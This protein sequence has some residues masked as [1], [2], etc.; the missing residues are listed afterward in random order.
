VALQDVA[1]IE[2]LLDFMQEHG[3]ADDVNLLDKHGYSALHCATHEN[4]NEVVLML[5]LRC[6]KIDCTLQNISNNTPLHYFCNN[7]VDPNVDHILDI[8]RQKHAQI[9]AVNDAGETPLHR[10]VLNRKPL[11][12]VTGLIARQ[13]NVNAQTKKGHTP[14]HYC[15]NR[16]GTDPAVADLLLRSGASPLIRDKRD[17]SPS[18]AARATGQFSLATRLSN[19][20]RVALW[21]AQIGMSQYLHNFMAQDMRYDVLPEITSSTLKD[22]GIT[23]TGHIM[24]IKKAVKALKQ[25][26]ERSQSQSQKRTKARQF[27]RESSKLTAT[28]A[29][30]DNSGSERTDDDDDAA[31]ADIDDDRDADNLAE[32]DAQRASGAAADAGTVV[33]SMAGA[34]GSG[35]L[36]TTTTTAIPFAAS[37]ALAERARALLEAHPERSCRLVPTEALETGTLLGQGVS[38]FVF[39]GRLRGQKPVA[40][41][42]AIKVFSLTPADVV[43]AFLRAEAIARI[44]AD[45]LCELTALLELRSPLIVVCRAVTVEPQ[46]SL[47]LD[48]YPRRSAYNVLH[49][50]D[51]RLQWK[52]LLAWAL[53]AAGAVSCMHQHSPP[54]VHRDLKLLNFLVTDADRVVMCDFGCAQL[55]SDANADELTQLKGTAFYAAPEV[56]FGERFELASDVYSLGICIWELVASLLAGAYVRPF[57]EYPDCKGDFQVFARAAQKNLRP[58]LAPACPRTVFDLVAATLAPSADRRPTAGEVIASLH[59]VRAAFEAERDAWAALE[60]TG[61]G[62][63]VT[64]A[65]CLPA[66]DAGP[67]RAEDG[68]ELPASTAVAATAAGAAASAQNSSDASTPSSARQHRMR[69]DL[70]AV[71]PR[72]SDLV[73]P[74]RGGGTN[75]GGEGSETS[76]SASRKTP[77]SK[78]GTMR[79]GSRRASGADAADGATPK[80]SKARSLKRPKASAEKS[81]ASPRYTDAIRSALT[82]SGRRSVDDTTTTP[83]QSAGGTPILLAKQLSGLGPSERLPLSSRSTGS[84]SAR[85]MGDDDSLSDGPSVPLTTAD[86]LPSQIA[87][88]LVEVDESSLTPTLSRSARVRKLIYGDG[89]PEPAAPTAAAAA[90]AAAPAVPA[91]LSNNSSSRT[92]R[93]AEAD[94]ESVTATPVDSPSATAPPRDERRRPATI[95]AP[96]RPSARPVLANLD[97]KRSQSLRSPDAGETQVGVAAAEAPQVD[98][99][100]V[101]KEISDTTAYRR[102]KS[103]PP[104]KVSMSGGAAAVLAARSRALRT[105]SPPVA[106]A[107]LAQPA[108]EKEAAPAKQT[109]SAVAQAIAEVDAALRGGASAESKVKTIVSTIEKKANRLSQGGLPATSED[110]AAKRPASRELSV[111]NT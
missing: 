61:G 67:V 106:P 60:G 103:P 73:S 92:S 23:L 10:A 43:D 102:A 111:T 87:L 70:D 75:S 39:R 27:R 71:S 72:R 29:V 37:P 44:E 86:V 84:L 24:K 1:V 41:R 19:A 89:A 98:V 30:A 26:E 53:D 85:S 58:T 21:L 17:V 52:S 47:A 33:A 11:G 9:D 32:F 22:M 3:R 5:L 18:D 62:A 50:P 79:D 68:D 76:L 88:D 8:F 48:E 35:G 99:H 108:K 74:R 100:S 7:Y 109:Q 81:E 82:K 110:G 36:T 101:F 25:Q 83:E 12:M 38:S 46:V 15:V 107:P 4:V 56:Y 14:L 20:E 66:D 80:R 64:G 95:A 42:V 65:P 94:V 105:P 6:P 45:F 16:E 97:D 2:R 49:E 31:A 63:H 91:P 51:Y 78:A 59:E 77:R 55:V 93:T 104:A 13:A 28:S 69:N 96:A 57:S 90:E 34:K 40:K 54:F